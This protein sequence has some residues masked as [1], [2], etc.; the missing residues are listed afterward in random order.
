MKCL[1]HYNI[2][3]NYN[4]IMN[5][6]NEVVL[7]YILLPEREIQNYYEPSRMI[8]YIE[9]LIIYIITLFIHN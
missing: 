2:I 4:P 9:Y 1:N 7:N 8:I 3:V 5:C 6:L